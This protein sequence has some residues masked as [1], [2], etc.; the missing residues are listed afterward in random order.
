MSYGGE[1]FDHVT[2]CMCL[3]FLKKE[4]SFTYL[5]RLYSVT[6]K[7]KKFMI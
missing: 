1:P 5:Q 4:A 3:S 2:S 6:N 7:N